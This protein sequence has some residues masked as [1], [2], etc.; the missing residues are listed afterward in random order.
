MNI[1]S[2]SFDYGS[3]KSITSK[4]KFIN[5]MTQHTIEKVYSVDNTRSLDSKMTLKK[6]SVIST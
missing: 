6:P 3:N 4:Q 1:V 5:L 2:H